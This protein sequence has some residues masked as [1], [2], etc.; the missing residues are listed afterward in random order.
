[1]GYFINRLSKQ[2]LS[3]GKDD[4]THRTNLLSQCLQHSATFL[5][6]NPDIIDSFIE[7]IVISSY[8]SDTPFR[9]D[10]HLNLISTL[11]QSSSPLF[12]KISNPLLDP[13]FPLDSLLSPRSFTDPASSFFRLSSTNPAFFHHL[14]ETHAGHL[15]DLALSTALQTVRVVSDDPLEPYCLD[16]GRA[17]Q[18]WIVLLKTMME[19]KLDLRPNSKDFN[20]I[21]S[22]ILTLLVLSAASTN[23]DLSTA[24]VSVFS[25]QFGLSTPHTEALLFTTPTTFPLSDTFTLRHSQGLSVSNHEILPCQSICAEAGCCVMLKS[26][27]DVTI[28]E[29]NSDFTR[30]L[31]IHFAGCLVNVLHSTTTAA[32]SFPFFSPELSRSSQQPN[33]WNDSSRQSALTALTTLAEI[34]LCLA[35]RIHQ[36]ENDT[37]F[38]QLERRD[39]IC[40]H[41]FPFLG[42]ESQKKFLSSFNKYYRSQKDKAH[43]SLDRLVEYLVLMTTVHSYNTPIALLTE[44]RTLAELLSF[45]NPMTHSF[46]TSPT[47]VS[48]FELSIVKRLVTAEGEERWKLVTQAAVVSK[49]GLDFSVE[50][51]RAENDAQ[52]LLVLS[53]HT[54][55]STP[56]LEFRLNSSPEAFH[57]VVE[58]AGHLDNLQLVA[59]AL[60]HIGDTLEAHV[61]PCVV[62]MLFQIE[63]NKM[64]P[65]IILN[66]LGAIAT[67][68]QEGMKKGSDWGKDEMTSQIVVSCLRLF[69]FLMDFDSFDPTPFVDSL[70]QL[71][72]TVD[73]TLLRSILLVLQQIEERTRTTT[74]PFSM[75]TATAPFRGIHESSVTQ[76]PLP[77]IISSVLLSAFL[78]S[79]QTDSSISLY[80]FLPEMNENLLSEITLETAK[81]VCLLLEEDRTNSTHTETPDCPFVTSLDLK[82]IHKTHQQIFII[83]HQIVIPSNTEAVSASTFLSLAPFFTRCLRIVVPLSTG[84]TECCSEQDKPSSLLNVF[85]SLVLSVIHTAPQSTL[86]TPPLSSLLSIALTRADTIPSSLS[87]HKIFSKMITRSKNRS[88]P[89]VRQV[90]LALCE[91]GMEDRSDFSL[92]AFSLA[93]LNNLKGANAPNHVD[94]PIRIGPLLPDLLVPFN[95]NLLGEER[96]LAPFTNH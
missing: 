13:N 96:F 27:S 55:R 1:M 66:A 89:Q 84:R 85:L 69:R 50:L 10:R 60:S 77:F 20:S 2:P 70:V 43:N 17:T 47:H 92:D 32:Q 81:T 65:G 37:N 26:R 56:N 78:Q 59:V 16:F 48:P 53:L 42:A 82:G 41:L 28:T 87:H 21:P 57:R 80:Q 31:E 15:L 76:Q 73:L 62:E 12:T 72:A 93:Y 4:Q 52:A 36:L 79:P 24:A 94:R 6:T 23:D 67:R 33:V 49:E 83:F 44:M 11:S 19:V 64:L 68:C 75:F 14:I 91:E 5:N 90:V 39:T 25:N 86:S 38:A 71:T 35:Y 18:N 63:I 61:L 88:N 58:Y 30:T 7:T 95:V 54:I 34:E 29:Q 51:M 9:H 74:T 45:I 40:V 46:E 8:P 3:E 22:S